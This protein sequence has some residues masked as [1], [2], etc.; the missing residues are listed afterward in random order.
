MQ[1]NW[2]QSN[3][4]GIIL[5]L[6][7]IFSNSLCYADNKN[8]SSELTAIVLEKVILSQNVYCTTVHLQGLDGQA[9]ELVLRLLDSEEATIETNSY[10]PSSEVKLE[11]QYS[12][13]LDSAIIVWSTEN[14]ALLCDPVTLKFDRIYAT[15]WRS[16]ATA[17]HRMNVL[18]SEKVKVED[19][20]PEYASGRLIVKVKEDFPDISEF[21]VAMIIAD[22]EN[23]YFLQF[24]TSG[25]AKKCAEYL[26]LQ[27]GIEYV[28][29]D[30]VVTVSE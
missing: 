18:Y 6:F 9:S 22:D 10:D 16:L 3:F 8:D 30:S 23:H 26:K 11:F 20:S 4:I 24:E 21:I 1:S 17:T 15:D 28:D 12:D 5:A 14:G 29:I 25:E 27:P 19:G 13:N 2:Y 7:L